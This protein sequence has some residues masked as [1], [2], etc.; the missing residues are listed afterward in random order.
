M[1]NNEY[2]QAEVCPLGPAVLPLGL[3]PIWASN[4]ESIKLLLEGRA[5]V[6]FTPLTYTAQN[7]DLLY[8]V[9]RFAI[10][11]DGPVISA[12]LFRVREL[13]TPLLATQALMPWP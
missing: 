4:N 7:C 12:R 1:I 6:G 13:V 5:S 11:S 2:C 9:P 3:N 8:V 10:F